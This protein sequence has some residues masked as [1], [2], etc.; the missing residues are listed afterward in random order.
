MASASQP[1]ENNHGMLIAGDYILPETT[2]TVNLSYINNANN[3]F[4]GSETNVYSFTTSQQPEDATVSFDLGILACEYIEGDIILETNLTE[5]Y[6]LK[7]TIY[8]DLYDNSTWSIVEEKENLSSGDTI[9][10]E[11]LANDRNHKILVEYENTDRITTGSNVYFYKTDKIP[12]I[13]YTNIIPSFEIVDF[14]IESIFAEISFDN[15][16]REYDLTIGAV[17]KVIDGYSENGDPIYIDGN[18]VSTI[19]IDDI[20]NNNANDFTAPTRQLINLLPNRPYQISTSFN[21]KSTNVITNI[22]R[23]DFSTLAIPSIDQHNVELNYSIDVQGV[24]A[25]ITLSSIT[26]DFRNELYQILPQLTTGGNITTQFT[27]TAN[28]FQSTTYQLSDLNAETTYQIQSLITHNNINSNIAGPSFTTGLATLPTI[29]ATYLSSYSPNVNTSYTAG[30][31]PILLGSDGVA[32]AGRTRRFVYLDI[33]L[34]RDANG[35][36]PR[37]LIFE[38]GGN[39]YNSGIS[40]LEISGNIH[41]AYFSEKSSYYFKIDHNIEPYIT[42]QSTIIELSASVKSTDSPRNAYMWINGV[43][44]TEVSAEESSYIGGPTTSYLGGSRHTAPNPNPHNF[45]HNS[46]SD[47]NRNINEFK[48]WKDLYLTPDGTIVVG[49]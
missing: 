12:D 15:I 3:L 31:T 7:A 2:Y 4:T 29:S 42:G 27:T 17:E 14:D 19:E 21:N 16:P 20:T 5:T 24:N 44:I 33:D 18:T 10:F 36:P 47:F 34:S 32:V 35:N 30:N 38:A 39:G 28:A 49:Q 43:L 46:G 26:S 40:V 48:I 41:F 25:T 6:S 1:H 37:G 45:S 23:E 8:E 22:S 11:Y 13:T 9:R